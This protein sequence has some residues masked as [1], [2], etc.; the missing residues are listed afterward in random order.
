MH[1]GPHQDTTELNEKIKRLEKELAASHDKIEAS[2]KEIGASQLKIGYLENLNKA[3]AAK[4]E[5]LLKRLYGKKSEKIDPRQL[6]LFQKELL[7]ESKKAVESEN[8]ETAYGSV[9]DFEEPEKPKKKRNGRAP[10]PK[11]LPRQRIEYTPSKEEL[12]CPGCGKERQR[13]D[14][15]VTE[16]LEYIPARFYV[17]EHVRGKYACRDCEEGV[18]I[19]DLPPF[20]IEKGRPGAGLLSHVA[21]SKYGD[22]LPLYRQSTIF[23]REGVEIPRSTLCDWISGAADILSPIVM[24]MKRSLLEAR[25]LQSDDTPVRVQDASK[26]GKC[27]TGYLWSYCLP[28][29]EVVFDFTMSRSREGPMDFL[30]DFKGSFLQVD[31]YS[32]F[33]EVL[34]QNGLNP[35]GCMAHVRR[36][37]HAAL[38]EAPN[39]AKVVLASIQQLYR[40]EAELKTSNAGLQERV[41]VRKEQALP[42][43]EELEIVFQ[44]LKKIALPQSELGKAITYALNQW[45]SIKRYTEVGEAE[46]DNNSCENTIRGVAV[47]R[48]NWLFCGSENGGKRAAILYS[49]IESCKRL[50]VEPFSYLKQVIEAIPIHPM[51]R[52]RELTPR[53]WK[54]AHPSD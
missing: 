33:N 19:A 12:I 25:L 50:G 46:I 10:L 2:Q 20:P 47:G 44:E 34:R 38:S 4:V 21:V 30:K 37:F 42:I 32:G 16:E 7:E 51:S 6:L 14:E 5:A 18:L 24:E 15:E 45:P 22:H 3:L 9:I 48:K 1:T 28:N 53:G 27:H 54:E 40:I 11:N 31:G 39:P 52:I 26:K 49:L 8:V 23:K 17:K 43:L 41:K 13:I 36:K 35:I 29:G